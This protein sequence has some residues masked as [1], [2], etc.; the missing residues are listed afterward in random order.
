M[1]E[2]FRHTVLYM[3]P[4]NIHTYVH[5]FSSSN[6]KEGFRKVE[7]N[8]LRQSLHILV[9]SRTHLT[10]VPE[11]HSGWY[12]HPYV[13]H[14]SCFGAVAGLVTFTHHNLFFWILTCYMSLSFVM[15]QSLFWWTGACTDCTDPFSAWSREKLRSEKWTKDTFYRQSWLVR[16]KLLAW[17]FFFKIV[18]LWFPVVQF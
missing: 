11:A 13:N 10:S 17:F 7:W 9:L 3:I 1:C 16:A 6:L 4:I 2:T 14:V 18:F 15:S 5:S 12:T 8:C